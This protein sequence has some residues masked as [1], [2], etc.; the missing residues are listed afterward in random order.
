MQVVAT[1]D[2][3]P[4]EFTIHAGAG[5]EQTG[6]R[7]LAQDLPA[8]SILYTDASYTDYGA[9]DLFNEASSSQQQTARRQNS[10]RPHHSA[11]VC[12]LQYFRKSIETCFS[13][14]TARF[15]KQIHAVTAAGFALKIALFIFAQALHQAGL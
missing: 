13:Q 9:E 10:K 7:S 6:R 11:Q 2:G 14:L 3:I 15:S 4:V 5:S 1:S 12:L 8:V